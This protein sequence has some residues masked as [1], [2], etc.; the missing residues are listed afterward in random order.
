MKHV[1]QYFFFILLV[2]FLSSC[3][4]KAS[5]PGRAFEGKIVQQISLDASGFAPKKEKHDTTYTAPSPSAESKAPSSGVG[6]NATIT[7][8]V[9]GDKVAYEV[10]MFGG[11]FPAKS[12]I[13]RNARTMTILVGKRAY[14]SNLRAADAARSKVDDSI[15]AHSDLLDSLDEM[16]PKPTGAKQ[17]INGLDCEEYK[18][19]FKGMDMDMWITQD[20]RLKFYDVMRDAFLGRNRTGEGGMEQIMALLKPIA[21][22]GKV[23]VKMTLTK[24]GKVFIKS[25]LKE[26]KEEK[27]DDDVFEIPKDYEI[28]KN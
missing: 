19:T 12:I 24:D 7:L 2:T 16:L 3:S 21:G 8:Y 6:I 11:L 4:D 23:P 27:V 17:T 22:E 15:N 5:M 28:V 1:S 18:G 20:P 14:V 9:R 25:E 26:L 10:G 13:D